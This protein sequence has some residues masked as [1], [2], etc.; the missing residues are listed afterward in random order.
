[1]KKLILLFVLLISYKFAFLQNSVISMTV[2]KQEILIGER[3]QLTVQ[4]FLPN[5]K[6]FGFPKIDSMAHFDIL[7][8]SGVDTKIVQGGITMKQTL[9]ITSWD[10]GKSSI[11]SITFQKVKT[12][13]IPV[14]VSF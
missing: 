4:V 8:R 10:S 12:K 9:S 1:M 3:I 6:T 7:E 2:D 13:P 11:P 5:H 14:V